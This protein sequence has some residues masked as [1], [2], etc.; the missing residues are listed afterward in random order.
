VPLTKRPQLLLIPEKQ[1]INLGLS[2]YQKMAVQAPGSQDERLSEMIRRVGLRIAGVAD[3]PDYQWEFRL[4]ADQ[5]QNAFCMPGGKVAMYEG[6][7]P[8]CEDEAGVATVMSHEVAHALARH[9]GERMSQSLAIDKAKILAE[10]LSGTY[11]P[12]KQQLLMAAYG[13]G[14]KYGVILP[15]SRKHELEADRIGIMLM[16]QAG[17]DPHAAPRLWEKFASVKQGRGPAEFFSTHP[18]D[19]HRVQQLNEVLAEATELY[20]KAPHQFGFGESV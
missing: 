18:S 13:A 15:F 14:S 7:L 16:A 2:A 3:R 4:V 19:R 10:K 8:I 9:G 12:G 17:Y 5:T 1:E 6:M 11:A 20:Q